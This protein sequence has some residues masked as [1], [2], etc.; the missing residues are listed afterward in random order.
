MQ[1]N[2]LRPPLVFAQIVKTLQYF[3]SLLF[4]LKQRRNIYFLLFVHYNLSFGLQLRSQPAGGGRKHRHTM[5]TVNSWAA[6]RSQRLFYHHFHTETHDRTGIKRR[7]PLA[8]QVGAALKAWTGSG[9]LSLQHRSK[10]LRNAAEQLVS[11]AAWRKGRILNSSVTA[12]LSGC[13]HPSELIHSFQFAQSH[14]LLWQLPNNK[15][16]L[17]EFHFYG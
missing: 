2:I 9:H 15:K 10:T 6:Q 17:S 5:C 11:G 14:C 1:K 3:F 12:W 16:R 8:A 7:G 13:V 4:C